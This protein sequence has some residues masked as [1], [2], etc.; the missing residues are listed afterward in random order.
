MSIGLIGKKLGMTRVY[1]EKG[2]ITGVT[3]IHVA[4]NAV[5]RR[6][7][8]EKDGYSAL[9]LAGFDASEARMPKPA[10]GHLRK[11]GV[12]LKR[13]LQEFRCANDDVVAAAPAEVT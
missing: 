12:G 2:R 3:V 1:D 6:K 7:T 5:V 8:K 11:N 10:V 4:P 13:K 9:P